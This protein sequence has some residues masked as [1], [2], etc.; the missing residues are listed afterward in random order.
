MVIQN[1]RIKIQKEVVANKILKI[2]EW[3]K[4]LLQ[5]MLMNS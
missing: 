2:K 3:I 5:I 4:I 1:M